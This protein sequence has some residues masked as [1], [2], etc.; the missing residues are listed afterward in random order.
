MVESITMKIEEFKSVTIAYMRN[1]GTYG[2]QNEKLMEECKQFL[3][4]NDLL[5]EEATLLG[6]ALDHPA[7]TP[8]EELRYDIGLIWNEDRKIRLP[9]RKI[10]DGRYAIFEVAHTKQGVASFWANIPQL[11]AG[12]PIDN[13]KPIIE[14]YA[15]KTNH[16]CEFCVPLKE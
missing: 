5:H 7:T 6:I 1:V 3:K 4:D 8:T 13:D 2:A 16:V 9:T 15:L 14:R 11:A 10:D 12:L